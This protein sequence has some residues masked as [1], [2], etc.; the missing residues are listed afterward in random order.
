MLLTSRL[1]Q[2]N[3]VAVNI[4]LLGLKLRLSL[5]LSKLVGENELLILT[6]VRFRH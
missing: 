6:G 2:M 1:F 4:V 5:A 3:I